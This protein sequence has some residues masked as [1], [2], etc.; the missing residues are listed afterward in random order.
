M[1]QAELFR[2]F[3]DEKLSAVF[4]EISEVF[5]KMITA[6]KDEV[7]AMLDKE[8]FDTILKIDKL[9]RQLDAISRWDEF[10]RTDPLQVLTG[11]IETLEEEQEEEL[12]AQLGSEEEDDI[13]EF[14]LMPV[15]ESEDAVEGPLSSNCHQYQIL[16]NGETVLL[17]PPSPGSSSPMLEMES[18]GDNHRVSANHVDS[19]CH[20]VE[21]FAPSPSSETEDMVFGLRL[22]E[23][24]DC[25]SM[26]FM[27]GLELCNGLTPPSQTP[28][29]H[30]LQRER[31]F[32]CTDCGKGYTTLYLLQV[33]QKSHTKPFCCLFCGKGFGLKRSMEIHMRIHTGEKPYGCGVCGRQFS[34]GGSLRRHRRLHSGERPYGC[35]VCEKRFVQSGHLKKHMRIHLCKKLV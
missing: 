5:E 18:N 13:A 19:A 15:V 16:E 34:E 28:T 20:V 4:E 32:A 2:A 25:D 17:S 23:T 29:L 24:S 30:Q 21:P 6:N 33:H 1:S 9:K 8:V 31:P 7:A 3:I 14:M 35:T 27:A 26:E 11:A 10:S 22:E 12:A